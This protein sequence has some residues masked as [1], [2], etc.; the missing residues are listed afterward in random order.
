METDPSVEEETEAAA[1]EA[2]AIG[3]EP[4]VVPGYDDDPSTPGIS[5]DPARGPVEEAGGGEAEGFEQAEA[6]LRDRAENPRG[7]S[8]QADASQVDEEDP[9]AAYGE[10]DHVDST[11]V[12][13]DSRSVR[14]SGARHKLCRAPW[15]VVQRQDSALWKPLSRFESGLPST[16]ESPRGS[17]SGPNALRTARAG[18]QRVQLP[19]R[20]PQVRGLR[21]RHP[22]MGACVRAR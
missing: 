21:Q 16:S 6:Q 11:E 5:D 22:Q 12:D 17:S 15:G 7:P 18:A 8:P 9:G 10:A 3:G 1:E 20:R 4:G 14:M 19:R 2:G 13:S